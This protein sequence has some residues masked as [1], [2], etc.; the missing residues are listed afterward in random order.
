MTRNEFIE[1]YLLHNY[2]D[3]PTDNINKRYRIVAYNAAKIWDEIHAMPEMKGLS[4]I[5][6][7]TVL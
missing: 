3:S 6:K 1:Q 2:K 4:T 7:N 5:K